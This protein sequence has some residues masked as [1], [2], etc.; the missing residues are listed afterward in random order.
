MRNSP[1]RL[2]ALCTGLLLPALPALAAD[3]KIEVVQS[4]PSQSDA[5]V[6]QVEMSGGPQFKLAEMYVLLDGAFY[7]MSALSQVEG[8]L[9]IIVDDEA[10]QTGV[11]RAYRST[12]EFDTYTQQQSKQCPSAD[13][14]TADTTSA[15]I[16]YNASSCTGWTRRV[17]VNCGYAAGNLASVLAVRSFRLGCGT[18]F[19]C[20]M[21][22]CSGS[23]AAVRGTAGTCYNISGATVQCAGCANF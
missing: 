9:S 8:Q 15:C 16:F 12:E 20:P 14:S 22:D 1:F 19:L 23:C 13:L 21:T 7:P 3:D 4:E 17:V 6:S 5:Q 10:L 18:T 11:A 2:L